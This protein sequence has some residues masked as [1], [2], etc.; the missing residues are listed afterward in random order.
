VIVLADHTKFGKV[1]PAFVLAL[2][3]IDILISDR[4]MPEETQQSLKSKNIQVIL[5]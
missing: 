1:A 3:K 5:A 2:E 4:N